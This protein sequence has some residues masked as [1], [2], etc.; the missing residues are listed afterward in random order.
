MKQ[1]RD[2][3]KD[4]IV[5]L[6]Q[7][8]NGTFGVNEVWPA[9]SRKFKVSLAKKD[10]G[11][12]KLSDLFSLYPN[13]FEVQ[14]NKVILR[15]QKKTDKYG[16]PVP[17]PIKPLWGTGTQ[18]PPPL[19][20]RGASASSAHTTPHMK[21][22]VRGA[23]AVHHPP[24]SQTSI[25]V[26]SSDTDSDSDNDVKITHSEPPRGA[27]GP[28]T[29]SNN[30]GFLSFGI[31][32]GQQQSFDVTP[33]RQQMP[34]IFTNQIMEAGRGGGGGGPQGDVTGGRGQGPDMM[35]QWGQGP[36]MMRQPGQ[37][38]DMMR[39]QGHGPDMRQQGQGPDMMRQQGQ[40]PDMLRQQGHGPD[41]MRQQGQGPDMMRQQGQGPDM[42]RQQGQGPIPLLNQPS[43]VRFPVPGNMGAHPGVMAG[44]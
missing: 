10:L 1:L 25:N 28:R 17:S 11:L 29:S 44:Q 36:D 24:S 12:L 6:L 3:V 2:R 41:M 32:E 16:M 37:G 31:S 43:S 7:D 9:Y 19:S 40:G 4:N 18:N 13:V 21:Q 20:S 42:M 27:S 15:T 33:S 26:S 35:R 38:P 34:M 23:T 22:G 14:E 8:S 5:E 39:Q 30:S